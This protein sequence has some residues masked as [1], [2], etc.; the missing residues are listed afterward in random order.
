M[1][2]VKIGVIGVGT[3]GIVHAT[4][5]ASSPL[6]ELVGI[7]ELNDELRGKVAKDFNT[8]GYADYQQLIRAPGIQAVSICTP[9]H[10][11]LKPVMDCL[12]ANL[13]IILEKPLATTLPDAERIAARVRQCGKQFMVAYIVRFDPR[14]ALAKEAVDRLRESK[15]PGGMAHAC[16]LETSVLLYLRGDLVQMEKAEKDISFAKT[17]YFYWD[18]QSASPVFFQEWFSRYSRTGTVGDPTKASVEKGRRFTE[19][20][21]DRMVSVIRELRERKI[22][23]R[24]DHH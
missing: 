4:A 10:L 15:F 11:H 5:L 12:D 1:D 6:A 14:Y 7:A 22:Q 24:V 23:P 21:A 20:V 2:R 16:E 19:A 17:E 3:I 13:H 8:T 9:D 18:L